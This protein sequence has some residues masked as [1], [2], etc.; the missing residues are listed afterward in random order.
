MDDFDNVYVVRNFHN[1]TDD[2]QHSFSKE[3]EKKN[4]N[5][6]GLIASYLLF[7]LLMY[8]H[9]GNVHIH[10]LMSLNK[11]SRALRFIYKQYLNS[12]HIDAKRKIQVAI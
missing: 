2:K 4:K 3:K 7:F 1:N 12:H 8:M 10:R 6:S 11:M 9:C 5:R